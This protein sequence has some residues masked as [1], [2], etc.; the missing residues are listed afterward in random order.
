MT[1]HIATAA[2]LKEIKSQRLGNGRDIVAV[3]TRVICKHDRNVRVQLATGFASYMAAAGMMRLDMAAYPPALQTAYWQALQ[4]V[5]STFEDAE[6]G[7]EN[8]SGAA[9]RRVPS[10]L[11]AHWRAA[12]IAAVVEN[13]E[14]VTEQQGSK[15]VTALLAVATSEDDFSGVA[16]TQFKQHRGDCKKMLRYLVESTLALFPQQ[17]EDSQ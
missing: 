7:W 15:L 9:A 11:H 12:N 14:L 6:C 3:A 13:D 1:C 4:V 10:P 8:V 5:S 17:G 2:H 16:A